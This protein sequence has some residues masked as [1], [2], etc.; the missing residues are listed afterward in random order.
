MMDQMQTSGIRVACFEFAGGG[1]PVDASGEIRL[2][3]P[4]GKQD[5]FDAVR[6][7]SGSGRHESPVQW[8]EVWIVP[9]GEPYGIECRAT[10][11]VALIA[12]DPA[13]CERTARAAGS[14]AVEVVDAFV[15][16]DTFVRCSANVVGAA[17][18]I[19]RP[20][21]P[22]YLSSMARGLAEHVVSRYGRPAKRARCGGLSPERVERAVR[23]IEENLSKPIHVDEIAAELG[24][25]PFHFARMFKQS[26]GYSPHFFLTLKR[27]DRA[28]EMLAGTALP[29]AEVAQRLGYSTQAHFTGVFRAYSGTTP[30]AYRV[31]NSPHAGIR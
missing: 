29:L 21:D 14:D 20:P 8:P 31:R 24:L 11:R 15:A 28:K 2:F 17:F 22:T 16:Y 25:S 18:R 26:T 27:M 6:E 13:F 3:V 9:A 23:M 5:G 19:G 1:L 12:L 30:R 10:A 4:L 7:A